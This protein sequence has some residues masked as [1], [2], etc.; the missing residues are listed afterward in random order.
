MTTTTTTTTYFFW[1]NKS[2]KVC[3]HEEII[4]VIPKLSYDDIHELKLLDNETIFLIFLVYEI[5]T[6][7]YWLQRKLQAYLIIAYYYIVCR[8]IA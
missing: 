5:K 1:M 8:V 6:A 3:I 2:K 4:L 7:S